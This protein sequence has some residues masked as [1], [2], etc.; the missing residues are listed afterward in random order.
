MDIHREPSDIKKVKEKG[1]VDDD[2]SSIEDFLVPMDTVDFLDHAVCEKCSDTENESSE[3]TV[4]RHE[5]CDSCN[6]GR[7]KSLNGFLTDKNKLKDSLKDSI[8]NILG[9]VESMTHARSPKLFHKKSH[10]KKSVSLTELSKSV[11]TTS[12]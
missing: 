4:R 5:D 10:S 3:T 11:Q 9:A 8:K 12:I 1:D 7:A 2:A 6:I